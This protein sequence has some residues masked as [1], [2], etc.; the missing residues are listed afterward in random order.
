MLPERCMGF[1]ALASGWIGI[2]ACLSQLHLI[3]RI[4][5]IST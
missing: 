5:E 4:E 2:L 3:Y 1:F